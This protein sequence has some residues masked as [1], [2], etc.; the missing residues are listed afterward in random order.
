MSVKMVICMM[1]EEMHAGAPSEKG[2][3]ILLMF[4]TM[5]IYANILVSFHAPF[6]NDM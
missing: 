2:E 1:N 4:A 6:L 5:Y 3:H